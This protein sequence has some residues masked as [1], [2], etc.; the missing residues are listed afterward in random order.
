MNSYS[1]PLVP[2]VVPYTAV[3]RRMIPLTSFFIQLSR[4]SLS[5]A[6]R[7]ALYLAIDRERDDSRETILHSRMECKTAAAHPRPISNYCPTNDT[8]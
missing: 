8:Y 3:R 2:C 5:L 6:S 4:E 1:V 7:D